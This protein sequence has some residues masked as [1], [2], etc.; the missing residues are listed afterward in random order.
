ME[1]WKQN[2]SQREQYDD[3]SL[4]QCRDPEGQVLIEEAPSETFVLIGISRDAEIDLGRSRKLTS[5]LEKPLFAVNFACGIYQQVDQ[6]G[7]ETMPCCEH[8]FGTNEIDFSLRNVVRQVDY[9]GQRQ[10]GDKT[11]RRW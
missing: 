4:G 11:S 3:G 5:L 6:R 8:L 2:C 7:V 1:E 10:F 9:A